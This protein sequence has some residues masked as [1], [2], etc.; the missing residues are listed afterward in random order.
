MKPDLFS[1][2]R[3]LATSLIISLAIIAVALFAALYVTG[4][5][6][7]QQT[8]PQ[9]TP[10]DKSKT[11]EAKKAE[12]QS[13]SE[14]QKLPGF[15][16]HLKTSLDIGGHIR[17]VQGDRPG[18]FQETR[19]FPKGFYMRNLYMNFES[20]DSPFILSLKALEIRE[21]DQ[22]YS[23][24]VGRVGKF[25]TRFLWDQVPHYYS[26]GRSFYVSAAPG[27]LTVDPALRASLEAAPNAGAA[28]LQLGT[29]L[30]AQ[31]LQ[32]TQAE[33]VVDLRVRWDK[34]LVTHSYYPTENLELYFRAQR[35]RSNGARPKPTGTFARQIGRA[36]V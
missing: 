1:R 4:Q 33:R 13:Q 32:Q 36:H 2:L 34:L 18:K 30:P 19:D 31:L 16:D 7:T 15:F 3:S 25:R 20:A 17:Q 28:T 8:P 26:D 5:Q 14:A 10:E 6:Q 29:Q 35:L 11:Q 24:E 21:R 9:P 12:G 23:A 22:S 27:V